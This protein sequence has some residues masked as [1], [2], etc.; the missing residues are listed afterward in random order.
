VSG[1]LEATNLQSRADEQVD[2][3]PHYRTLTRYAAAATSIVEFGVR[4]GVSTWALL[5]GLPPNGYLWSVDIVDCIVAPRVSGDHR[6][7]FIVGDDMDRAVQA[8]LPTHADL[9]FLDTSHEYD[10]T[11][12][13]LA[14]LLTLTPFRIVEHDYVMEPVRQA[15]DEFCDREGWRL[16]DNELPFGLATLEPA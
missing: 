13:E 8:K 1:P 11:V 12:K 3:A 6:W 9:V 15:T 16:V 5:V 10:H 4:G 14:F 7:T 2:M